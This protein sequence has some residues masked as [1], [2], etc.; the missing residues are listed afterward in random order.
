MCLSIFL[1]GGKHPPPS[2]V[3]SILILLIFSI[4]GLCLLIF[5]SLS[6]SIETRQ[7]VLIFPFNYSAT[8]T[9]YAT[10][11]AGGKPIRFG[12][13]DFVVIAEFDSSNLPY[14]ATETLFHFDISGLTSICT[15]PERSSLYSGISTSE[16]TRKK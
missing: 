14:N 3:I 2:P 11:Q 1:G 9:L 15:R 13:F 5:S 10:W 12:A 4:L 7:K 16:P 6:S 8:E